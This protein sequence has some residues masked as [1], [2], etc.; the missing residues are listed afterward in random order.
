MSRRTKYEI[1]VEILEFCQHHA[2]HQSGILRELRLKT[3]HVKSALQFLIDRDL[4]T[5]ETKEGDEWITYQTTPKGKEALLQ[6]Y[7][8]ITDYFKN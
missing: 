2:R 5:A 3:E 6:F 1:W 4:I 8:L 7:T